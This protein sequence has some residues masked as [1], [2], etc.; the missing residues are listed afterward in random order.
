MG[1]KEAFERLQSNFQ[2]P[3][4]DQQKQRIHMITRNVLA[5]D[6][7]RLVDWCVDNLRFAPLPKDFQ[8]GIRVL[9][10][11]TKARGTDSA[12]TGCSRCHDG[13]VLCRRIK[14]GC[15]F[16]NEAH[17]MF[18]TKETCAYPTTNFRCSCPMGKGLPSD[19]PVFSYHE[20][21]HAWELA[22]CR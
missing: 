19:I 2:K 13:W 6:F 20:L 14:K 12:R 17:K 8:D 15:T 11:D 9:N 1:K 5:D 4:T 16:P 22:K 3:F 7:D 18:C 21:G 10:I